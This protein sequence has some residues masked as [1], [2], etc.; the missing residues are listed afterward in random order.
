LADE[1]AQAI[2]FHAHEI[3]FAERFQ[4]AAQAPYARPVLD[5]RRR[6]PIYEDSP[7]VVEASAVARGGRDVVGKSDLG[8]G[9]QGGARLPIVQSAGE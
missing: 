5:H 8:D 9:R 3:E 6:L 1:W 7:E 4:L 2:V